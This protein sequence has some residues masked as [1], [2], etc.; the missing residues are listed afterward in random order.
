[1][2]VPTIDTGPF[3]LDDFFA[4]TAGRP[5]DERWELIEGEPVLN[6]SASLLHQR[7]I[8]NVVTRLT[9]V[10]WERGA[11]WSVVP[12]ISTVTSPISAPIPDILVRPNDLLRDWKCDDVIVAFEVLSPSTKDIDMRWKRAAY[13]SLPSLRH[14]VV[15]AQ[16]APEI[17]YF[18]HASGFAE[19]RLQGLDATLDLS[20]IDVSLPLAD[21]YRDCGF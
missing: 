14:Y 10:E 13:A 9:N 18:D 16:D 21:I 1:M 2:G 15:V 5:D 19:R 6:A 8:R 20:V 7:I 17:V 11:A 4:F 3:S 12:G